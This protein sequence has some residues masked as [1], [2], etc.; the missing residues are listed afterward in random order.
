M[1]IRWK[2]AA[3]ALVTGAW[4]GLAG[5]VSATPPARQLV[6]TDPSVRQGVLPNGLR[7]ALMRNDRPA[8]GLSIRLRFDVGSYEEPEAHR[9][10]AHFLEHMAFNGTRN[11][12]EGELSRRFAEAGVAFG[13]DQ[14]ASTSLFATT[15]KLDLPRADEEAL[16]LAFA[17][18]RDVGDGV[19]LTEAAVAR[20]QGVVLAEYSARLGPAMTWWEAY[21]AFAAP[22]ARSLVRPPIGTPETIRAI[23]RTALAAFHRAWYRP[24]NAVLVAV[25]DLPLDALE[26]RVRQTFDDWAA[27]TGPMTR[28]PATPFDL[29]R[30]LDVLVYPDAVLAASIGL[31]RLSPWASLEPDS[32]ERRRTLITRGL[33]MGILN[34]RL[35]LLSQGV[36]AP[37]AGAAVAWSPWSREANALCLNMT[38]AVGGDWREG[39][40]TALEEVRRLETHGV[41]D[42]E[43]ARIVAA[44]KSANASAVEQAEDRYSQ[45]LV[46]ALASSLPLHGLDPA[47]FVSPPETVSIYDRVVAGIDADHI[48]ADFAAAWN[49]SD[50]LISVRMPEPPSAESIREVWREVMDGPPPTARPSAEAAAVWAY[51]NFG[52][53]G[54]I[55]SREI[56][57]TPGFT[58]VRFENGVILN[59]KTIGHTRDLVQ[60]AV[61]LGHGRSG[62]PDEDYQIA[63]LGAH[64]VYRGGLGRHSFREIQELFPDRR[65]NLGVQMEADVFQLHASTR[66]ADLE[67]QLQLTAA[68]LT[69]PG[70]R[71][72]FAGQRRQAVDFLYRAYRTQPASVLSLA[73][74]EAVAPGSP[75]GLPDR[76]FM[77]GL[78]AADFERLY[79]PV[80]IEAP[81]EVTIVG[82]MAEDDIIRLAATTFG[83]L[84]PRS[85]G[86]GAGGEAFLLRYGDARPIVDAIHEGAPDQ[87]VFMASWPL[88]VA[89][90]ARRREQ[91]ALELLRTILQDKVRDEVREA[92]GAAYSPAV[93]LNFEDG[94]DQGALSVQVVTSPGDV[95]R[96]REA[97]RRV[98]AASAAGQLSQADLDNAREP[99]LARID[100]D[101][102]TN[103]WWYRV[104]NG[105]ARDPQQLQDALDW[106]VDYREMTLEEVKSAAATWLAGPA[107]EGVAARPRDD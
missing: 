42:R 70:F 35:E 20:E 21:Q 86:P 71:D 51:A 36:D 62:V 4:I 81:L 38:P 30:P 7:Y 26:D 102:A 18:L 95:E 74:L 94:G 22:E 82:D 52:P 97:V 25:G 101:R 14:N 76:E 37:F 46:D 15:Y 67:T 45:T 105:S 9:G 65:L 68:M 55:A 31:C 41:E 44:Q 57:P 75:R 27:P 61:Q 64:F 58:R 88:F 87:A 104:L 72:D 2:A 34:R 48:R 107:I 19:L 5:P 28:A 23:D 33:W 99:I 17:W 3:V 77:E 78:T 24:D 96:V 54:A 85:R 83:A 63:S 1:T 103:S 98:V 89:D 66:P 53:A 90:P 100:D 47:G 92:L 13:R 8:G 11:L 59:V 43:I 39:L 40:V 79:R 12:A 16:D 50:P 91:R 106:E 69:D 32:L 49:A 29:E 93:R 56:V 73:V 6:P 60:V 80:L 84:P 10:V